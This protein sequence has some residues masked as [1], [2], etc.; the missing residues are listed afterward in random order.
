MAVAESRPGPE[1]QRR[2]YHRQVEELL[3]QVRRGVDDLERMM[4][5]RV[6]DAGLRERRSDLARARARL[7]ALVGGEADDRVA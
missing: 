3:E 1:R 6:R 4:A 7:A 5:L 2:R